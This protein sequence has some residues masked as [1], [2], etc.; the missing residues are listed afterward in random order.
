MAD[1]ACSSYS[2]KLRTNHGR[3]VRSS[4]LHHFVYLHPHCDI[5]RRF[6]HFRSASRFS[7]FLHLPYISLTSQFSLTHTPML[8]LTRAKRRLVDRNVD[9]FKHNSRVLGCV[10]ADRCR[11]YLH[12]TIGVTRSTVFIFPFTRFSRPSRNLK[13]I[14]TVSMAH[15]GADA[16]SRKSSNLEL[17][18]VMQP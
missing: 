17:L 12:Q 1:E 2:A 9:S 18:H 15:S 4:S 16:I 6:T 10:G 7:L 5:S 11:L 13:A 3:C 8:I 14:S